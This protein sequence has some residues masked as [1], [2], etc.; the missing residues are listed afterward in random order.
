MDK[1]L[2][3]LDMLID[4]AYNYIKHGLNM[5]R[6]HPNNLSKQTFSNQESMLAYIRK[7]YKTTDTTQAAKNKLDTL[8]QGERNYWSQ[9]AELNKLIIKANKTEE[10]KVDLLKKNISPKIK[11]LALTLSRKINDANYKGQSKQIDMFAYNLQN[12][13]HYAKLN[14][15][16]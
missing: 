4:K 12:Y 7:H 16:K 9:K 11:N 1:V 2:Y 8:S 6:I 10:Q 13:A 15:A 3:M 5:L 14:A